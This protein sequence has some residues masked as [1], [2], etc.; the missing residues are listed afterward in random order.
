MT[1][2][3][4]DQFM[5]DHHSFVRDSVISPTSRLW[6]VDPRRAATLPASYL[7]EQAEV[8]ILRERVARC[9]AFRFAASDIKKKQV[10]SGFE[11]VKLLLDLREVGTSCPPF[12]GCD[13]LF[14]GYE[15]LVWLGHWQGNI[16][17]CDG[18][19]RGSEEC[20]A[21]ILE[22][23]VAVAQS[24]PFVREHSCGEEVFDAGIGGDA[25]RQWCAST[26]SSF[27]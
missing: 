16:F 21:A 14:S 12:F 26:S 27:H 25:Q 8:V 20:H 9:E 11:M 7:S 19:V 4:C 17:V 1:S 22:S 13:L 23:M 6:V 5:W 2:G 15:T 18:A 24:S 10:R 3:P